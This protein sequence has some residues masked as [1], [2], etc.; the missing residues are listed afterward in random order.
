M[1]RLIFMS[2]VLLAGMCTKAVACFEGPRPVVIELLGD[3][4]GKTVEIMADGKLVTDGL[5]NAPP[6]MGQTQQFPVIA[7]DARLAIRVT[8]DGTVRL[9]KAP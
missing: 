3:Y 6:G 4:G 9:A 2:A 8:V 7:R 1:L 5:H